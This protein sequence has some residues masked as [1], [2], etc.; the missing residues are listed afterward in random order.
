MIP[1]SVVIITKNEAHI[2]GETIQSVSS[3]TDDIIIVD[4]GSTDETQQMV[5]SCGA[6]LIETNWE[7]FG[8]NKNKGIDKARYDW[9]LSID[10]DEQ[11]D[12]ELIKAMYKINFSLAEIVYNINFKTFLGKKLIRYGEW[13]KDLHIRLFNKTK[14]RWNDAVVHE[15]LIIPASFKVQT[16]PGYILHYTMKD[17][18]EYATKMT[19]YALLSA[20]RYYK[21][22]KKAGWVKR[23]VSPRFAFVNNYFFKLGFLDGKEGYLIAKMTMFYTYIKY[24]RLFELHQ[25]KQK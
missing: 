14:I 13:G 4:S 1:V 22:L 11:P 2:I 10:A 6:T 18:A 20:D 5:H 17:I 16:L 9:I 24:M 3:F 25:T 8:P 15:Q 21:E 19:K 7:G 23:N 12:S